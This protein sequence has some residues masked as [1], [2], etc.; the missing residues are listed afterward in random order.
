MWTQRKHVPSYFLLG[1]I[2]LVACD[3]CS[4][5]SSRPVRSSGLS[6]AQFAPF[7]KDLTFEWRG[8]SRDLAKGRKICFYLPFIYLF[9]NKKT[10]ENQI[11]E[12]FYSNKMEENQTN[13]TTKSQILL[14][15]RQKRHTIWTK[16]LLQGGLITL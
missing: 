10:I 4:S 6:R 15:W 2:D 8:K 7:E 5:Q 12:D 16:T 14:S 9:L 11:M 1:L 13:Y 3:L